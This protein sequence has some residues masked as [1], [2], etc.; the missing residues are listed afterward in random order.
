M[1]QAASSR[2][3]LCFGEMLL[4]FSPNA[5]ELL[6]QSP[7]LTVRPAGAEANVAVSLA[8]FGA[9][10]G[11][12]TVLADNALGRGV[13]DLVGADVVRV[14]V[15]AIRPVGQDDVGLNRL[16]LVAQEISRLLDAID[17]RARIFVGG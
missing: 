16:E 5:N 11:M 10:T 2:R 3:I 13:R 7:A 14:T 6:M 9:P 4:R 17:Q 8:R 15:T 1:T 12:A